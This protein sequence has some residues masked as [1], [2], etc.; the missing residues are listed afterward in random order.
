MNSA[1][2]QLMKNAEEP[3]IMWSDDCDCKQQLSAVADLLEQF[4]ITKRDE[5]N[6]N[7]EATSPSKTKV[8]GETQTQVNSRKRDRARADEQETVRKLQDKN[9][10]LSLLAEENERKIVLLNEEME[11]VLQ[12]RTSHIEQLKQSCEEEI[13]RQMLKMRDMRD[14]LLWYK[15]QLAVAHTSDEI[16]SLQQC[17]TPTTK[18]YT[19][20]DQHKERSHHTGWREAEG[21]NNGQQW[22][23]KRHHS[24]EQDVGRKRNL[25]P[26]LQKINLP[27]RL[28]NRNLPPRLQKAFFRD[29]ME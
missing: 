27:P 1:E 9:R 10:E 5:N 7:P 19:E 3:A 22:T 21:S 25:P 6:C 2:Q 14:E 8:D 17:R 24:N 28:Q 11:Q 18:R 23:T 20:D 26:R 16:R 15:E 29:G 12:D 13:Q 4:I